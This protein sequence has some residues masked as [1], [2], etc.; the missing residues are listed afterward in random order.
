MCMAV[1]Y[2]KHLR[3]VP[4]LSNAM[5]KCQFSNKNSIHHSDWSMTTEELKY[6]SEY[7]KNAGFSVHVT[8]IGG[9]SD[10]P[11]TIVITWKQGARI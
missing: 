5:K 4:L 3:L 7:F 10:I 6:T 9:A 11:P 2:T 1:E 8:N